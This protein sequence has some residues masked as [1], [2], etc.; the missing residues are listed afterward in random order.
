M[1]Q[2]IDIRHIATLL[3]D[4]GRAEGPRTFPG[5][6][7]VADHAGL[8]SWWADESAVALIGQVG[9]VSTR[10][11]IY[12][13]QAGA[14]QPGGKMSSATLKSRILDNHI[15]GNVSSSTFRMTISAI[16]FEPFC[17]RLTGPGRLMP[18]DN[19]RVSEW[20]KDHLRVAMVSLD[21]RG[22]LKSVEQQVLNTLDPPL[23][24]SGVPKTVLR[25]RLSGLRSN[26][27]RQV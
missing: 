24:L 19:R 9:R 26:L 14:T 17:L 11:C 16:L 4:P 7:G 18:D 2:T 27:K 20:I 15:R 1:N 3:S 22:A 25:Q 21:D 10:H 6:F 23:N 8:Y 5:N 12:V 13:G